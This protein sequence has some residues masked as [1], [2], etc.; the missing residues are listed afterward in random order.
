MHSIT[1]ERAAQWRFAMSV[2]VV[3]FAF[4]VA[5]F[6]FPRTM[7]PNVYGYMVYDTP[8]EIWASGFMAA[9][10]LVLYGLHINGRWFWSPMIRGAGYGLVILMF[11][12]VGWSAA[13]AVDGIHLTIWSVLFFIPQA[14][15]FLRIAFAD[16][17]GRLL[18]G[19]SKR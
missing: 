5:A 9:A 19:K 12:I 1:L 18:L 2:F 3:G 13:T 17:R 8:A 7:T 15:F 16:M 4:M 10:G 14:L 11:S 6:F